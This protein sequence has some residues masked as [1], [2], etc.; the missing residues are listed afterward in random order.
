MARARLTSAWSAPRPSS[1][2]GSL[3]RSSCSRT[4]RCIRISDRAN[5]AFGVTYSSELRLLPA[6]V[7]GQF[8]V[9]ERQA[10]EGMVLLDGPVHVHTTVLA[11]V[12]EDGGIL[13]DDGQLIAVLGDF[14]LVIWD[15][16]DD[17][18]EGTSWLPALGAAASMLVQDVALQLDFDGVTLAVA[19]EGASGEVGVSFGE[20]VVDGRVQSRSHVV[21]LFGLVW[22]FWCIGKGL[23]IVAKAKDGKYKSKTRKRERGRKYTLVLER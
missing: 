19:F 14:D 6:L 13:V 1:P 16:G 7:I 8:G 22:W 4:A 11:G 10:L 9:H 12:A 15:N 21:C 17:G 3:A 23:S 20:A 18:E 5:K 2:A